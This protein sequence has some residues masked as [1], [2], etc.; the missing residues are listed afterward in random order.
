LGLTNK[1]QVIAVV[2][3]YAKDAGIKGVVTPSMS[4][5]EDSP[6]F[7]QGESNTQYNVLF[8]GDR[9]IVDNYN[10]IV[11][12]L[13]HE[14]LHQDDARS[15]KKLKYFSD[16]AEIYINQI[17][18]SSFKGM[19]QDVQSGTI[20]SAMNF[21]L[22]EAFGTA[23]DAAGNDYG[24]NQQAASG[25]IEKL[26]TAIKSAGYQVTVGGIGSLN[27]YKDKKLISTVEMKELK[28]PN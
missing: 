11:N 14:K 16:H 2:N 17:N 8:S 12:I 28:N 5:N 20:Q 1:H 3:H 21:I 19:S 15:G 6:A 13:Y 22:N 26:N 4:D 7:T 18:H 24:D 23:T 9:K 25:L 10:N 27:L